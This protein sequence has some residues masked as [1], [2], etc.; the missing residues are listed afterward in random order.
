MAT[1]LGPIPGDWGDLGTI[2]LEQ[3]T[4]LKS[5]IARRGPDGLLH[6]KF[7]GRGGM[8]AIHQFINS[9]HA[10]LKRLLDAPRVEFHN[11]QVIDTLGGGHITITERTDGGTMWS[12]A[13][14]GGTN[15]EVRPPAGTDY[16]QPE[17]TSFVSKHLRH[18]MHQVAPAVLLPIAQHEALRLELWP[19]VFKVG[20]GMRRLGCC[21]SKRVISLSSNL[22]F[23]PDRQLVEYVICHELAHLTYMDHSR[24]FHRLCNAYVGGRERKLEAQLKAF[25]WP[26]AT[27]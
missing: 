1:T 3:D 23:I 15:V 13:H 20:R 5:I 11:G 25:K 4:R 18:I 2:I 26:V 27:S 24:E 12:F 14:Q 8:E 21:S 9:K 7:S 22:L 17:V 19:V 16:S 10:G 6:I